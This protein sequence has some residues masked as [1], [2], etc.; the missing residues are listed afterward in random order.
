MLGTSCAAPKRTLRNNQGRYGRRIMTEITRTENDNRQ[1]WLAKL[2]VEERKTRGIHQQ[3]LARKLRQHQSW[4]S[5]L[6]SGRRRIDVCEFL[7]LA[8]AIGFNPSAVLEKIQGVVRNRV[9]KPK[10]R[11]SKNYVGPTFI[12]EFTDG[13]ITRMTTYT[14]LEQLDWDRGEHLARHAWASRHKAAPETAPPIITAR[15]ERNGTVLAQRNGG[16]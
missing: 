5:R 7:D 10:N 1:Q 8:K 3:K 15:F 12:A 6:E 9:A 11:K 2:L 16:R 14:S 4:V 13:T